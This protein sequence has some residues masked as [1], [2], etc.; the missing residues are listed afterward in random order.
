MAND[1][2]ANEQERGSPLVTA[3]D[4]LAKYG[5]ATDGKSVSLTAVA[6]ATGI[7]RSNL[8]RRWP[9]SADLAADIAV[10]RATPAA[11]WH[12]D[13]CTDDGTSLEHALRR[14]LASPS[15]ADGA[16]TRASISVS[17]RSRAQARVAAWERAH[18][19]DLAQRLQREWGP[20][21]VGPWSDIAIALTALVDGMHLSWA[22]FADVPG[23]V[24]APD[25]ATEVIELA[26]R[27]VDFM[28]QESEG[29]DRPLG[30]NG[31]HVGDRAAD[32]DQHTIE[33][34]PERL[35]TALADGSLDVT[36]DGGRRAVDM[37]I[38]ARSRGV[39]ERSLYARWPAPADLNAD[40]YLESI[41]RVL[42]GIER[43]I[44]DVFQSNTSG[45]FTHPMPLF[46]R[47]NTWF[48]DPQRFPEARVHLGLVDVLAG[49]DVLDRVR[50]PI[51]AG[52]VSI[53]MLTAGLLQASGFR[54]LPTVRMSTYTL[55]I[56]GLGM[57][58]H[59]MS[60]L[61]PEIV[62]RRLRFLDDE[63][64]AAGVYLTAMTRTCADLVDPDGEDGP[65]SEPPLPPV[66]HP[67]P[68]PE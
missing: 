7:S 43:I 28:L 46:A 32:E 63:Y 18:V 38:L 49:S 68:R 35:T 41:T 8:Y 13:V 2:G 12:A 21:A 62:D 19:A 22:Q 34:L 25:L 56:L 52:L 39:S 59:R 3:Y 15:S 23:S 37:G 58:T 16:L 17:A 55:F 45:T 14:S 40:L 57:G 44:L 4:Q 53:D 26:S 48:M 65:L 20:D 1:N 24:M 47:M 9:T 36:S 6:R 54:L 51:Q 50:G 67:M 10:F 64:P 11:G 60:A 42:A 29:P 61:H 31:D 30:S 5:P 33:P 66:L 27:M